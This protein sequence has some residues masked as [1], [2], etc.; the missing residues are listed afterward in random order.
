MSVA[1]SSLSFREPPPTAASQRAVI[2][3]LLVEAKA[4]GEGVSGDVLR[5]A[6][7]I[8]Q[9]PARIWELKNQFGYQIATRQDPTTRM[10]TYFLIAEP[11]TDWRPPVKQ[12]KLKLNFPR[13]TD[14]ASTF[15]DGMEV[16]R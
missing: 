10:A 13:D 14:T 5:H 15:L 8:P 12:R 4:R 2:A 7:N 9:A 1:T 11:S 6:C 3:R 16:R